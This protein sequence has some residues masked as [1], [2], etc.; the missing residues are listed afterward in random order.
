M[1]HAKMRRLARAIA[2][3]TSY[4]LDF[5]L[6]PERPAYA[7]PCPSCI[8]DGR[9][10]I[11]IWTWGICPSQQGLVPFT[12]P[13]HESWGWKFESLGFEVTPLAGAATSVL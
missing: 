5:L 6:P 10:K 2:C 3:K 7:N 9:A 1:Y 11:Q 13:D 8:N 4:K 12:I